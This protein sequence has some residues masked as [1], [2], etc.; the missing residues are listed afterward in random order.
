MKRKRMLRWGYGLAAFG[1]LMLA[2]FAIESVDSARSRGSLPEGAQ[3]AEAEDGR[4]VIG[5]SGSTWVL[6]VAGAKVTTRIEFE[7]VESIGGFG[8][9][10]EPSAT[11]GTVD[12]ITAGKPT[13]VGDHDWGEVIVG[14]EEQFENQA[15]SNPYRPMLDVP[16]TV[17]G[18]GAAKEVDL[19]VAMDVA[20]PVPAKDDGNT[21]G[22]IT[23]D[24]Y[25][26]SESTV[27]RDLH[28]I[29]MD[30]ASAKPLADQQEM[31]FGSPES[32]AI[33]GTGLLLLTVGTV[34]V[35]KGRKL[36]PV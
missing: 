2:M 16:L 32:L 6:P 33:L 35:L 31:Q 5:P 8:K 10:A 23:S 21:L 36:S 13:A 29:L 3:V 22:E 18:P 11:L 20:Y 19:A 34:L 1:V 24:S 7:T 14:F 17:T 28:L 26:I 30:A 15:R 9:A 27:D 25:K 4:I 12:G